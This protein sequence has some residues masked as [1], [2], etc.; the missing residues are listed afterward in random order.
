MTATHPT[1]YLT[2]REV[3]ELLRR[4]AADVRA[5]VAEGRLRAVRLRP[6]G[7]LLFEADEVRRALRE[8]RPQEVTT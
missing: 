5:L 6:R 4:S 1:A 3:A 8:A 7:A 2:T